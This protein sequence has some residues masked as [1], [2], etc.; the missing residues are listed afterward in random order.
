MQILDEDVVHVGTSDGGVMLAPHDSAGLALDIG[1]VHGVESALSV[2]DLLVVDV[3]VPEGATDDTIAADADGG[4]GTNGIE[5]L[6]KQPFEVVEGTE[7]GRMDV[8][9]KR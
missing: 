2:G 6:K 5:S 4:H 1:E 9:R 8:G 7:S 3:R